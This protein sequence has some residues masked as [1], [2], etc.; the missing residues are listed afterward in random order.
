MLFILRIM[1]YQIVLFKNKEK[2]STYRTLNQPLDVN[3]PLVVL[4]DEQIR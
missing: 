4:I 1:N 3:I 2:Q